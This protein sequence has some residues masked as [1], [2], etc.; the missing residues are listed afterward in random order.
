MGVEYDV[1]GSGDVSL[2]LNFGFDQDITINVRSL[3]ISRLD[4]FGSKVLGLFNT[5]KFNFI[6]G[7]DI[8]IVI[9]NFSLFNIS[10]GPF[11]NPKQF[12]TFRNCQL[13][14]HDKAN[15]SDNGK[16]FANFQPAQISFSNVTFADFKSGTRSPRLIIE[17]VE[18]LSFDS[19][20]QNGH[21][22]EAVSQDVILSNFDAVNNTKNIFKCSKFDTFTA[23]FHKLELDCPFAYFRNTT[24]NDFDN[25]SFM[26]L[27]NFILEN[28]KISGSFPKIENIKNLVI[29]GSIEFNSK[30]FLIKNV[31]DVIAETSNSSLFLVSFENIKNINITNRNLDFCYFKQVDNIQYKCPQIRT[32]KNCFFNN[33]NVIDFDQTSIIGDLTLS[34]INKIKIL[35]SNINNVTIL[36]NIN[37]INIEKIVGNINFTTGGFIKKISIIKS[38]NLGQIII[39]NLGFEVDE[40]LIS[41]VGVSKSLSLNAKKIDLFNV[42]NRNP[43]DNELLLKANNISMVGCNDFQLQLRSVTN[44]SINNSNL[45]LIKNLNSNSQGNYVIENSNVTGE[46]IHLRDIKKLTINNLNKGKNLSDLELF[47]GFIDEI[48]I[49]NSTVGRIIINQNKNVNI[50]NTITKVQ[51][52]NLKSEIRLTDCE[53]I[54]LKTIHDNNSNHSL[55]NVYLTNSIH[56]LLNACIFGNLFTS[57]LT[58][59][60]IQSSKIATNGTIGELATN[61]TNHIDINNSLVERL[62]TVNLVKLLIKNSEFNETASLNFNNDSNNVEISSSSFKKDLVLDSLEIL[63]GSLKIDDTNSILDKLLLQSSTI[64]QNVQDNFILTAKAKELELFNNKQLNISKIDLS[65]ISNEFLFKSNVVTSQSQFLITSTNAKSSFNLIIKDSIFSAGLEV[66]NYIGELIVLDSKFSGNSLQRITIND[67]TTGITFRRCSFDVPEIVFKIDRKANASEFLTFD[68]TRM[69]EI[70]TFNCFDPESSIINILDNCILKS[71]N[72]KF[73]FN[74]VQRQKITFAG[75]VPRNGN[76]TETFNLNFTSDPFKP[77]FFRRY[78]AKFDFRNLL[79]NH[80]ISNFV[81]L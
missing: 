77:I 18:R 25:V 66:K 1:T 12:Y 19:C 79:N 44:L 67:F 6:Q 56:V 60:N 10:V 72:S 74:K 4:I 76:N 35:N 51:N 57:G 40:Y 33:I 26:N 30:S 71:N 62:T 41:D 28:T 15:L 32:L 21:E 17:T 46:K 80:F 61:N 59:L 16:L 75:I 81:L 24:F 54:T 64:N 78:N 2:T 45:I 42:I 48:D 50:L 11:S 53:N 27:V 29:R 31:E 70:N 14:F 65:N 58:N 49:S 47:L 13:P 69:A 9:N 5:L 36:E 20:R 3:S 39:G 63:Q 7:N 43:N 37:D 34:N 8:Q 73:V 38:N 52:T 23:Q 68:R 22:I 55:I